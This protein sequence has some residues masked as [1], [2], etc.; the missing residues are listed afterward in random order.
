MRTP[1]RPAFLERPGYRRRRVADAA[2]LLPFAGTFL[3]A[4][5]VLWAPA[6]SH[7]P[8]TARGAIYVFAV[9]LALIVAAFILARR[10]ARDPDKDRSPGR[11]EDG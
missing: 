8:D 2:R 10:L 7:E 11:A 3:F 9:W 6:G 5:P 1:R 4:L